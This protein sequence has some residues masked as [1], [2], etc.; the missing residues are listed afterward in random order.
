MARREDVYDY[1]FKF[2]VVGDVGVGK[3]CITRQFLYHEFDT[4]ELSTIGVDYGH[5]TLSLYGK[6]IKIAIWDTAGQEVFKS[7]ARSYYTGAAACILVYNITNRN[8][9]L[10]VSEWLKEARLN[11]NSRMAFA[12]V[13][14]K[15]DLEENRQ[16]DRVDGE[17]F[18][19]TNSLLFFET[20]AKTADNVS[21]V[22]EELA[23]Y[24]YRKVMS[25]EIDV[26][27]PMSGVRI[28]RKISKSEKVKN[29]ASDC[30]SSN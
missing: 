26:N 15:T 9:F 30:C 14:N 7:I 27:R 16:V 22:F 17:K 11:S 24:L 1:L 5:K 4:K 8:S 2:I 10:H 28:G 29:H 13:G 25:G 20:S 6:K 23:R 18:S 21:E 12:L 19:T 3:T